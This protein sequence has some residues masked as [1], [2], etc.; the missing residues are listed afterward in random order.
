[1]RVNILDKLETGELQ[2]T[3][4]CFI[5]QQK[6]GER[7]E[8]TPVFWVRPGERV[9]GVARDIFIFMNAYAKSE[10]EVTD[11]WQ[12]WNNLEAQNR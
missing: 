2:G 7:L 3:F 10:R 1:M 5:L 12:V 8:S 6:R 4:K 9:K 11:R